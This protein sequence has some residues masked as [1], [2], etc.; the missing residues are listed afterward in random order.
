MRRW[1]GLVSLT[2][3]LGLTAC[4]GA[5]GQTSQAVIPT[6]TVAGPAKSAPPSAAVAAATQQGL[7]RAGEEVDL[8]ARGMVESGDGRLRVTGRGNLLLTLREI[9][10]APQPPAGWLLLTPVFD[11]TA[12]DRQRRPVTRLEEALT[13]RFSVPP[14]TPAS[15]LVFDGSAW[16]LVPS[17]VDADGQVSASVDHLTPY[18]AARPASSGGAAANRTAGGGN[19]TVPTPATVPTRPAV[20]PGANATVAV[21]PVSSDAAA[22]ALKAAAEPLKG[23]PVK[24]TMA[25][26]YSGTAAGAVPPALQGALGAAMS[27]GGAGYAGIYNGVNEAV[28]VEAAG[29][30]ASGQLTL[31]VE[32]K[33]AM[34]AG[35]EDA[36]QQLASLFP[37]VTAKLTAVQSSASGCLFAGS[38]DGVAYAVGFVSYE[39]VP[40]AYA[41]RGSGSYAG[42]VPQG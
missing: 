22:R 4:G 35:A 10:G 33:T 13:L 25:T 14:G 18:V 11:V 27:A 8:D 21:S 19:R 32:P 3:L 1:L 26:G 24:I 34:P 7:A 30:S 12:R 42:Y 5:T 29:G 6:A 38:A 23:K 20:T 41:M 9:T 31:L 28:T 17:E 15:L 2:V 40:L 16:Q 39:G 37:G 36:Q